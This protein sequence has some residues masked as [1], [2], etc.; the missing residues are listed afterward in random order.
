MGEG[1]ICERCHRGRIQNGKCTSCGS[2]ADTGTSN[3]LPKG[4]RLCGGRYSIEQVL[5]EGGYGITY[6]AWDYANRCRVALKEF[7]PSFALRR[8]QNGI[9]TVCIDPNAQD[10]LDHLRMRF[11]EEA[12]LLLSLKNVKEIVDAYHSFTDNNTA[13]YTMEL[14]QGSDM[15]KHLRTYGKMT[16]SQLSPIV[17]QILRA[18]YAT[19]QMGYIHRDISPDNIFLLRGGTA[20]LIDFGNARRYS[21]NQQMTAVVKEK[22]APREQYSRRGK[23]G[24]WTDIY[25]LCVTIYYA[26]TGVLPQK[27]TERNPE[28]ETLA[29][30]RTLIADIPPEVS[31]AVQRGMSPDENKRFQTIADLAYAMYPNQTVLSGV[32]QTTSQTNRDMDPPRQ[33]PVVRQPADRPKPVHNGQPPARPM[34][35]CAQGIMKGF[36]LNLP[37]GQIQSLGRGPVKEIQYADGTPG[38]SR[39]QCSFLLHTNG[40]VYVRDDYSSFGTSVNGYR[41]VPGQWK[42]LKRG[43][44]VS[45]GKEIYLLK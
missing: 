17:I 12:K 39:N 2:P 37:A 6:E 18:L 3:A 11:N 24:P 42:A 14:L 30:L 5:G 16:W 19:H 33:P 36:R 13:Y 35:L 34:L 15:Q 23:Q 27:A 32:V 22:F 26:M 25:S 1:A 31:D 20:R 45:F 29:P 43:D 41:L 7:F 10:A 44:M 21:M 38:V 28:Q 8:D 40:T 9:D 4:H